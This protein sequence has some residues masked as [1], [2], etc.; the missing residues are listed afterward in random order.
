M[1]ATNA[2]CLGGIYRFR[3]NHL[4][5]ISQKKLEILH[6]SAHSI[7]G[8]WPAADWVDLHAKSTK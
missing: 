5:F 4:L 6:F 3:P 1:F 2:K 8:A 7:L